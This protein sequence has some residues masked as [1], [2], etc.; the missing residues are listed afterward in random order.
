[1]TVKLEVSISYLVDLLMEVLPSG[2]LLKM[3]KLLWD[4]S[5][6]FKWKTSLIVRKDQGLEEEAKVVD[7]GDL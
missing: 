2:I 1:M 3:L 7:G 6:L 5:Q 4:D